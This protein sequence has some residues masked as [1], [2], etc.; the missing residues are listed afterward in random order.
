MNRSPGA[1]LLATTTAMITM[2]GIIWVTS[3]SSV[4]D[5]DDDSIRDDDDSIHTPFH[6][7]RRSIN[8]ESNSKLKVVNGASNESE[9]IIS[10]VYNYKAGDGD[11]SAEDDPWNDAVPS[12]K[13][14]FDRT[15][16]R[17]FCNGLRPL[18]QEAWSEPLAES[19][20]VRAKKYIDNKKKKAS[21]PSAFKLLCVDMISCR[22]PRYQG[23]CTHPR[24]RVQQ[25]LKR[26]AESGQQYSEMPPFLFAVNLCIPAGADQFYHQVSYFAV[27]D[28]AEIQE[29]RTPFGKLMNQFI[30]GDSNSFRD[31]TF[32]LIPRI[33]QGNYIVRKAVGSKP[34][35]I[36]KKLEQHYIRGER[37]FEMI[38]VSLFIDDDANH[39]FV[40]VRF[41][42]RF[43]PSS[44]NFRNTC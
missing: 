27:Q 2:A 35:I 38:V 12:P 36:G 18:R 1:V 34:S 43:W 41:L 44:Y 14:S 31:Q 39:S 7:G 20:H 4:D 40:E 10:W 32:K 22:K 28:L 30:F 37:F 16:Y 29:A 8:V 21:K 3:R 26:E 42:L 6:A 15:R 19:F 33:N 5:S 23:I 24:E 25:A 17:K 11:D 9:S 13:Q